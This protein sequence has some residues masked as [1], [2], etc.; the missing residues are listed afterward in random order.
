MTT[1]QQKCKKMKRIASKEYEEKT[2]AVEQ[3]LEQGLKQN[4]VGFN[5][6]FLVAVVVKVIKI[7]NLYYCD[8]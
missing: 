1:S 8:Y 5:C 4:N 7:N 3:Q 6:D 2:D